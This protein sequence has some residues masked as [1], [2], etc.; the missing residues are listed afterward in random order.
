MWRYETCS[1]SGVLRAASTPEATT[2]PMYGAAM[3][4]ATRFDMA[5]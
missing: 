1:Y 4:N 2:N 3:I 5:T